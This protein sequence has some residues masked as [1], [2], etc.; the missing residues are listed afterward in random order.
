MS[1][2]GDG[3]AVYQTL[4]MDMIGKLS[5]GSEK[6]IDEVP[7]YDEGYISTQ[8]ERLKRVYEDVSHELK[9]AVELNIQSDYEQHKRLLLKSRLDKIELK[10]LYYAMNSFESLDLCRKLMNGKNVKVAGLIQALEYYRKGDAEQSKVLFC[11]FFKDNSVESGFYLANK[12]YGK[13][14]IKAGEVEK[15]LKHMEYAVQLKVDDIELLF[16]LEQAYKK[17][18]RQM[19]KEVVDEVCRILGQGV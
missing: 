10:L 6:I 4:Q 17:T 9:T 1:I 11:N 19:E 12:I 2:L 8:I 18:G 5:V 15:A 13:L 14:L 3:I 7:F 16:L